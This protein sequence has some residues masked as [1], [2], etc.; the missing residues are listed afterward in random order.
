LFSDLIKQQQNVKG[1]KW[2]DLV[3]KF[4]W[5]VQSSQIS[6]QCQNS[7]VLFEVQKRNAIE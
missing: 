3:I 5:L 7:A 6:A 2:D 4:E 1:I